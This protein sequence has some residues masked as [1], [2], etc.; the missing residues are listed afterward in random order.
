MWKF[1]WLREELAEDDLGLL[2]VFI[3]RGLNKNLDLLHQ[4]I[5]AI[6]D[7]LMRLAVRLMNKYEYL[8]TQGIY[9]STLEQRYL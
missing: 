3:H 2:K 1:R 4:Y 8:S 9:T 5:M 6:V 7:I